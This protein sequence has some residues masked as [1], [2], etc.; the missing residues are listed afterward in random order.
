M[1]A[2]LN[3]TFRQSELTRKNGGFCSEADKDSTVRWILDYPEDEG[4]NFLRNIRFCIPN[5][6]TLCTKRLKLELARFTGKCLI[7]QDFMFIKKFC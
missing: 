7:P 6:V 3:E 2:P 1:E 5:H 4:G